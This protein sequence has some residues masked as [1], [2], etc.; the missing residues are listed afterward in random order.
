MTPDLDDRPSAFRPV[1]RATP[2]VEATA[3]AAA[4]LVMG[5]ASAVR[6]KRVFHPDGVARHATLQVS[7]ARHGAPLLDEAGSHDAIV[8]L[9]RG[10]GL[11]ESLPDFLGLALR[12]TDAHGPGA[13]QDVLLV[14]SGSRPGLRHALLPVRS[15]AHERYSSVVPYRVG[16]RTVLFGARRLDDDAPDDADVSDLR[17]H[18]DAMRFALEIAELRGPWEPVGVLELGPALPEPEGRALRFDPSN[19]GGGIEPVGV[20]QAVRRLAYRSSQAAR[21]TT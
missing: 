11:P 5:A 7:G 16:D 6:R 8:R 12:V 15:F 19:T 14:S 20:V 17:A 21:P 1:G 3:G 10:A 13:H 2:V 4:A 18:D 9:S